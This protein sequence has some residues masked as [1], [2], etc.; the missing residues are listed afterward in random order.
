MKKIY[1]FFTFLF[2]Q[3]LAA[4]VVRVFNKLTNE[5]VYN[6]TVLSGNNLDTLYKSGGDNTINNDI[7]KSE[8]GVLIF[9]D[10][11]MPYNLAP[12]LI[13]SLFLVPLTIDLQLVEIATTRI[14]R[15]KNLPSKDLLL[16]KPNG[17]R[18]VNSQ[19]SADALME[20]GEVYIQKSQQA[21]GSPMIGG[22]AA[23][24]ILY[25]YEG[26]RVSNA[27]FR[28]G[29]LHA[30][31]MF[32]PYSVSNIQVTKG[33][34]SVLYGSDAIGGVIHYNGYDVC[35]TSKKTVKIN[36]LIK[37]SSI[38][39]EK[40]VH[41]DFS[42]STNKVST[43]TSISNSIFDDLKMGRHGPERYLVLNQVIRKNNEDIVV[44][45]RNPYIQ[46]PTAYDQFNLNQKVKFSIS[47]KS[48]IS[49]GFIHSKTSNLP[50]FDRLVIFNQGIPKFSEW[51]YGPQRLTMFYGKF[52]LQRKSKL[53]DAI[54][55]ISSYQ[56]FQESRVNRKFQSDIRFKNEEKVNV[57]TSSIDLSKR[58]NRAINVEY[59]GEL[60]LNKISSH[61]SE[62]G[63]INKELR[64]GVARY[65]KSNWM[66]KGFYL[67]AS[68][69]IDNRVY[70]DAGVRWNDFNVNSVFGNRIEGFMLSSINLRFQ[71]FSGS[72]GLKWY[73]STK[74]YLISNLSTGYRAPNVD[75][76]GKIFDSEPGSVV[77]PNF[78]LKPELAYSW[79]WNLVTYIDDLHE[80]KFGFFF[81]ILNGAIQRANATHNGA[82]SI[83]YQGEF[84]QVQSLQNIGNTR[85]YGICLKYDFSI[86]DSH[87]LNFTL[88]YQNGYDYLEK[89]RISRSRH[90]APSF[91]VF[92]YSYGGWSLTPWISL[93]FNGQI[94][95][96]NLPKTEQAKSYLYALDSNG[97]P[98][99][100]RWTTLD[101]GFNFPLNP[102]WA[103]NLSVANVF[104]QRYRTYSSGVS[105]GGRSLNFIIKWSL[106]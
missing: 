14:D 105:A 7:L 66:S 84:S 27:I 71:A 33:P 38:N 41:T 64:K 96:K 92:N 73:I 97:Q 85:V 102:N 56:T 69:L 28:G 60:I 98:F 19:T 24:R 16:I 37:Y 50:R 31:I 70:I 65:P 63:I 15:L 83:L 32:D 3:S 30:S 99:S 68:K 5:P 25:I 45:N 55:F 90:V 89:I 35:F 40:T 104:N 46:V 18:M 95:A 54:D 78:H 79:D 106:S 67:R 103:V 72:V 94:D 53:F 26:I 80:L 48:L 52:K 4:Q 44:P 57:I 1:F 75:D 23:N 86:E 101:L 59:G 12:G 6:I 8:S 10:N 87:N 47:K 81:T 100:P 17:L 29:N 77:V 51:Y 74:S 11:Y 62:F 91:G 82:D 93:N 43:F 58:L 76:L 2:C 21:G 22:F 9:S 42:L 61:G 49:L 88:N 34:A 36:S 20:S 13:D 39:T